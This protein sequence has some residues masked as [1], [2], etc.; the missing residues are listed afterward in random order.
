[1]ITE[2]LIWFIDG[3]FFYNNITLDKIIL[4]AGAHQRSIKVIIDVRVK[5]TERWYWHSMN[6]DSSKPND[7][8]EVINNKKKLLINA[9]KMSAINTEI[10]ITQSADHIEVINSVLAKT[11]SGL[12]ILEDTQPKQRHPIFQTLTEINSPVLLLSNKVWRKPISII[13]AVDP[14]H[15]NDRPAEIDESIVKH[16]MNWNSSLAVKWTLAH[17]CYIS[18]VL[19]K[20][21]SKVLLMHK[22]G[23]KEFAEQFHIKEEQYTLLEGLPEEALKYL[24]KKNH[25]DILFIGLVNR[26]IFDK[27][28]VG[29]TTSNFL[30]EP[31]CDL[32]LIK[33]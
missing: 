31:P 16:L 9:L 13:G 27:L 30:Y 18:S 26:N 21:K 10:I 15:E 11:K 4:L 1:M 23:L 33:H 17:C 5:S 24:I 28:W 32:Y 6:K 14:L 12:L 25:V 19:Y 3:R 29:S 20:Y 2:Q 22:E 8:L 7:Q